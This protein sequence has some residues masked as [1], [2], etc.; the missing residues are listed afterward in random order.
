[1]RGISLYLG[2]AVPYL[3]EQKIYD[4]AHSGNFE[5]IGEIFSG[6]FYIYF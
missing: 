6:W 1:M 3:N 4:L 5:K 2:K